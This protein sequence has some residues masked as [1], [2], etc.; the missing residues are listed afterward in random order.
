[1]ANPCQPCTCVPYTDLCCCPPQSGIS[2]IQPT[3]QTLSDGSVVNNPCF[4]ATT[5]KSTWT[6]K[7]FT[8]CAAGT[9]PIT[10]LA[11]P[12]CARIAASE[13]VVEEQIDGCGT[14][15][16]VPFTLAATDPT[17]GMAPTGF[18][19]LIVPSAGRYTTGVSVIYRL[20]LNGDFPLAAQPIQVGTGAGVLTL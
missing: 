18:Q 2:V 20:T 14:F 19:F 8:D 11:I 12:V 15:T 7:F 16:S 5:G 6:Y 1:M 13:L 4:R 9:S 3:C 17:F 10:S